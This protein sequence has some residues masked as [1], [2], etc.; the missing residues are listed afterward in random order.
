MADI[1]TLVD[2]K[3]VQLNFRLELGIISDMVSDTGLL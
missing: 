3:N 1:A 2:G